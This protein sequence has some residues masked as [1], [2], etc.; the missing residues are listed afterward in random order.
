MIGWVD[1]SDAMSL[2]FIE[3][4]GFGV[5]LSHS[6]APYFKITLSDN[7]TYRLYLSKN[8]FSQW[9]KVAQFKT[10]LEAKAAAEL[11]I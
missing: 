11:L 4:T 10:M 9:E 8:Q 6:I 7:G 5:T 2:S 1:H 3:T